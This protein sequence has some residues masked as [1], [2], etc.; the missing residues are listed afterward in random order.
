MQPPES[1]PET[2][3]PPSRV[4]WLYQRI[5]FRCVRTRLTRVRVK[6]IVR[7]QIKS[8]VRADKNNYPRGHKSVARTG[9]I[10]LSIIK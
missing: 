1:Y 10:L 5:N 4:S 2:L 7:V 6:T 9:T 3:P 8:F